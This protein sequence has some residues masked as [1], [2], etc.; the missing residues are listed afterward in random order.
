VAQEAIGKPPPRFHEGSSG[1]GIPSSRSRN[2]RSTSSPL[3]VA[4]IE[5]PEEHADMAPIG[6]LPLSEGIHLRQKDDLSCSRI[7]S[8]PGA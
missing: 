8:A 3:L 4:G 2:G 6:V 7:L 1:T 5:F